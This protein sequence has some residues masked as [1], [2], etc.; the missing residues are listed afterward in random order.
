[1]PKRKRFFSLQRTAKF[2]Q[3]GTKCASF[4]KL[5]KT[6]CRLQ[7]VKKAIVKDITHKLKTVRN[8]NSDLV[9]YSLL[10]FFLINEYVEISLYTT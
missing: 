5:L 6:F 1:M 8:R 2:V 10:F 4:L 9:K 7:H 3:S